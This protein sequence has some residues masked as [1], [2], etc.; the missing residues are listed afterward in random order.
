MGR[1]WT[2]VKG[3][4]MEKVVIIGAGPAGI[5]AGYELLK[6]GKE[7]DVTILEE[8]KELGGI[9]KTVC[10]NGNRMDIGGHRFFS[11][12]AEVNHWWEEILPSQGAPAWD[13]TE[14]ERRVELV[15]GG[16]DPEGTDRVMLSRHRCSSILYQ[17][18]LFDYPVALNAS[19]IRKMGLLT[20]AYAGFSYL[21]SCIH[22]LPED[23]LENF[24][25]NRFGNKLYSMFFE[26]Y[27]EKLWGKHPREISADWG[28]QRV[29]GLSVM[30]VIK[31]Y[32]Q[33]LL[34]PVQKRRNVETS[35]IEQFR[36]PKLGPGQLWEEAADRFVKMGGKIITGC[37]AAS[38]ETEGSH[39]T[40][41][42][43]QKQG[44]MLSF[45]ADYCISSMPLSDLVCG[46][47]GVPEKITAIAEGLPYRSFV[48]VGVL[49]SDFVWKKKTKLKAVGKLIPDCWIYVQDKRVR[50]GRI[51]IFNN[52]SP[53]LVKDA[54]QHVWMGLEYFCGRE[55]ECWHDCDEAW[56]ELA[57]EELLQ[58]G[59]IES[60]SSVLDYHVERVEKAYPAYFGTYG[61]LDELVAYL[62]QYE[63]LYCVGRNGQHRYNNMDHSMVTAFR[64]AEHIKN[65]Q[66]RDKRDV[67][68]VNT[69]KE[70]H[71]ESC[72]G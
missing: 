8:T 56:K 40:A 47:P 64:A 44:E 33:S 18:K 52:W 10:H 49:L 37:R 3:N 43:A 19:T 15:K 21:F 7:Y 29:K 55:E 70:Y 45:P 36:Y 26:T 13:D 60:K 67:W 71:E 66:H 23:S 34:C 59:L 50:M 32:I 48:T 31:N 28:V 2:D 41:V 61:Q 16:P 46:L 1:Q 51:Q 72:R 17:N 54:K 63:N 11:K 69:E 42:N 12:D 6:S 58:I 35:L 24:Y 65:G 20:T 14:L 4:G 27:T 53:Y 5:T 62:D 22:K 57:V 25:R 68:N 30:G 39:I 38:F 9:S